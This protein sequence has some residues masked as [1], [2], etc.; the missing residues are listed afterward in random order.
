MQGPS[1]GRVSEISVA[2]WL[3]FRPNP[4]TE[5]HGRKPLKAIWRPA[6]LACAYCW[7]RPNPQ[8]RTA[9]H[10]PAAHVLAFQQLC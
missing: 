4:V 5:T 6:P 2:A 1:S 3:P 9:K 7:L 10:T 8:K